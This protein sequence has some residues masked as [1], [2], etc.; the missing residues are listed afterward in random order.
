MRLDGV[1]IDWKVDWKGLGGRGRLSFLLDVLSLKKLP[2]P[3]EQLCPC[4]KAWV[5]VGF[6]VAS[7]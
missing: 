5:E 1:A 4:R 2:E 7:N 3:A 6:G